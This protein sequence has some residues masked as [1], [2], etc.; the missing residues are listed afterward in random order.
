MTT[1]ISK[2]TFYHQDK[3]GTIVEMYGVFS[4]ELPPQAM[5][6]QLHSAM[7]AQHGLG[8]PRPMFYSVVSLIAMPKRLTI[9]K[10]GHTE[11]N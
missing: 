7:V 5:L 10:N 1:D 11:P 3:A 8:V 4:P 9:A 6:D 2:Y